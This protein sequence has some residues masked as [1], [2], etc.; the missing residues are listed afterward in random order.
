MRVPPEVWLW[1][2]LLGLAIESYTL[3]NG[4]ANDTLTQTLVHYVPGF[5][6]FMGIGWLIWHFIQSYR[7]RQGR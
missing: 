4:V 6:V 3:T 2:A 1:W 5:A 7:S